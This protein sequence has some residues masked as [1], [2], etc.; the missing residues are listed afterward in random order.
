MSEIRE[1]ESAPTGV[2]VGDRNLS[3]REEQRHRAVP[4][5]GRAA[6]DFAS[7][8]VRARRRPHRSVSSRP[9]SP[10]IPPQHLLP[11]ARRATSSCPPGTPPRWAVQKARRSGSCRAVRTKVAGAAML[12]AESG[13]APLMGSGVARSM[14]WATETAEV[15]GTAKTAAKAKRMAMGTERETVEVVN[16]LCTSG[17]RSHLA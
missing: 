1:H 11:A 10:R 13:E 6:D 8:R 7:P 9:G 17:L 15:E 16:S 2:E 12:V 4:Q 3:R 14:A 5:V